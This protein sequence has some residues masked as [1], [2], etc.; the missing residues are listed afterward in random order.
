MTTE[1]FCSKCEED[2]DLEQPVKIGRRWAH[3]SCAKPENTAGF[4]LADAA[5]YAH[6]CGYAD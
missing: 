3:P 6:A 4:E 5:K 2:N 1:H